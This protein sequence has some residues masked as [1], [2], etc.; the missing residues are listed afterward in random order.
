[1]NGQR[2]EGLVG[3]LTALEA[4]HLLWT[5]TGW[6]PQVKWTQATTNRLMLEAGFTLLRPEL[7]ARAAARRRTDRSAALRDLDAA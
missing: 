4:S 6:T 2:Y 5:P 7:P 3:G 1:M